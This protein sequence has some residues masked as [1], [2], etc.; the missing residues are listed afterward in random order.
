MNTEQL[1]RTWGSGCIRGC[2]KNRVTRLKVAKRQ[3]PV[4]T[5]S[6]PPDFF[7]L[8]VLAFW[9]IF[10]KYNLRIFLAVFVLRT[11]VVTLDVIRVPGEP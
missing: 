9:E 1:M 4:E 6:Y 5:H 11:M 10:L 7:H 2:S 8:K 3:D